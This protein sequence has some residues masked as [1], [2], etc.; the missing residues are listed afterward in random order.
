[1]F[2]RS[3][4]A[5]TA[6]LL[7]AGVTT[8]AP[9]SAAPAPRNLLG[10]APSKAKAVDGDAPAF[11]LTALDGTLWN[12]AELYGT[13]PVVLAFWASYCAPCYQEAPVLNALYK[14]YGD[15]VA[16]IGISLDAVD[17]LDRVERFGK[18]L[19][20]DYPLVHDGEETVAE[21]FAVEGLPSLRVIDVKGN[22]TFE[23][24]GFGTGEDLRD[25][26]VKTLKLK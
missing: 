21:K 23:Q 22:I 19:K 6:A 8:L 5:A 24:N 17:G 11:N 10:T 20:L 25:Q 26:I 9:V 1:M 18:R 14:E 12:S 16:I 15:E 2:R 4:T 13:K 3:F 7:I